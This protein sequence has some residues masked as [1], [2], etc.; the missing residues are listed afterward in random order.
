MKSIRISIPNR[1]GLS[2]SAKLELPI[3][4][5]PQ[6]YA[7]FAHCFTCGKN[8]VAA[9]NISMA[10]TLERI[11]V[12]RFDFA[13]IGES[14]GEFFD[15]NFS[16]NVQDLM[17]VAAWMEANYEAPQL[18][19][20]HSLGGAA[21]LHAA[22]EIPSVKAVA[23]IGAPS[24]PLH[25]KHLFGAIEDQI[26][27]DGQAEI[28]IAGRP[29]TLKRHFIDSIESVNLSQRIHNLG[30]ALLVMHA[31]GDQVVGI[32]NARQI[33]EAAR[34][35]KSF[36]TLDGADHL[37]TQKKDSLYAGRMIGNWVSRYL[38]LE[39][40]VPVIT[41]KQAVAR[42]GAQGFVTEI[43]AGR[44]SFLADEPVSV[45]G[46]DLGPTPYDL[47]ISG[48]G[49]CTAMTMRMYADRKSWPVQE[50]RVHLQHEQ[51]YDTDAHAADEKPRKIDQIER[52]IEIEGDL[53]EAQRNKLME[54]ADRC[55]VHRTLHNQLQ[56]VTTQRHSS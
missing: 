31:P 36:L 54:I 6:A 30:K 51:V 24:E 3:G 26:K 17:D 33:Y 11:A 4:E 40:K 8:L 42:I 48:L 13:G 56:I 41:D 7:I 47:L 37:L 14:D 10:L 34:H 29:F 32:E 20:G 27:S 22:A 1:E 28:L 39:E 23:T 52:I 49:A 21:V 46:D 35:P 5:H 38:V 55:P 25:V 18:L 44:H 16:T 43:R 53:D 50:I 15:S 19:I 45:G 12:V 9:R 2:L